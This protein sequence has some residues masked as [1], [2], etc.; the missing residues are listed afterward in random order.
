MS[1]IV[2]LVLSAV[3]TYSAYAT[4]TWFGIAGLTTSSRLRWT[5]FFV[6]AIVGGIA[7]AIV[8]WYLARR[9]PAPRS[10]DDELDLLVN[11]ANGYLASTSAT[12]GYSIGNRPVVVVVGAPG[13]AKTTTVQQSASEA[14]LLAGQVKRGGDDAPPPTPA[15]NVWYTD[16]AIVLEAGGTLLGDQERWTKLVRRIQPRR[17]FSALLKGVQPTRVALLCFSCEDL[18]GARTK[19]ELAAAVSPLHA[20][21][22]ELAASL[23]IRLPVYVL[24]TKADKVVG[25]AE[26]AAVLTREEIRSILGVTLSIDSGEAAGTY[27]ERQSQLLA[28][29]FNGLYTALALDRPRVLWREPDQ[30]QR[31]QAYEFAREFRKLSQNAVQ[32]LVDVC[33]PNPLRP[34]PV[35][36]GFYFAGVRAV[37]DQAAEDI[38]ARAG[39]L[40]A[41]AGATMMLSGPEAAAAMPRLNFSGGRVRR[42]PEW[43]FLERLLPDVIL[44]DQSA[45]G[46][47]SG[48]VR[49]ERLRRGVLALAAGV[50][51][52]LLGGAVVSFAAN[53]SLR[54]RVVAAMESVRTLGVAPGEQISVPALSHLDTLRQALDR[55]DSYEA[56]SPSLHLRWGLYSGTRLLAP[57]RRVYFDAFDRILFRQTFA[58]LGQQLAGLN[59]TAVSADLYGGE[60]S[61]LQAYLVAT[62]YPDSSSESLA[63]AFMAA[64][65][66]GRQPTDSIK[67]L[68]MAQFIHY[69][70]S[71]PRYN[72]YPS[73][74][75]DSTSVR[76]AQAFLRQ[77][78]N[79]EPVYNAMVNDANR[80]I[81][82]VIFDRDFVN[83]IVAD[84]Y[85]VPG[86]YTRDGWARMQRQFDRIANYADAA[87]WVTGDKGMSK[88]D[89]DS[90]KTRVKLLYTRDY[91]RHWKTFL[92]SARVGVGGTIPEAGPRI[93]TL[94]GANSPLL[95]LMAVASQNTNVDT[96]NIGVLFRA[97]QTVVPP[98]AP[99]GG[100]LQPSNQQ[101]VNALVA[102]GSSLTT[103]TDVKTASDA[104]N[105]VTVAARQLALTGDPSVA[106]AVRRALEAPAAAIASIQ[107]GSQQVAGDAAN[108]C[109]NFKALANRFPIGNDTP[110]VSIKEFNDV[111]RPGRQC[112]AASGKTCR[113]C[114]A[115]RAP[116]RAPDRR[117]APR[118][119]SLPEF[120]RRARSRA[121]GPIC[122][123][124]LRSDGDVHRA[125]RGSEDG[126]PDADA[127]GWAVAG[128]VE[129]RFDADG[130]VRVARQRRPPRDALVGV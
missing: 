112:S 121:G 115:T 103:G 118:F 105:N 111:F 73:L 17:A 51:L 11:A 91:V 21:L 22:S 14:V 12:H 84:A 33:R 79:G 39:A 120:P 66:G 68:A 3:V 57:A 102:L 36:R 28:D 1:R 59:S 2:K 20:A 109:D 100:L 76:T 97:A 93:Q 15:V 90:L 29:R 64:W 124:A 18:L 85:P 6:L 32:L 7:A 127:N 117:P 80:A 99:G 50:A 35:L 19:E 89:Q 96:A 13:S 119:Q 106:D 104:A 88:A 26:T 5:S 110:D 45:L 61:A 77:F 60:F 125:R 54:N 72:P 34:S 67:N 95:R 52:I 4:A 122:S 23:G 75:A 128:R 82:P 40:P 8:V 31:A 129:R 41:A 37:L 71:L 83:A 56:T 69:A 65:Q 27:V 123:R 16:R 55:L 49:V 70:G 98:N 43:L 25:F 108:F 46:L 47:A 107:K 92:A 44:S 81:K 78:K 42:K 130:D 53:R 101:Y 87:Q 94:A 86:A 58:S 38:P 74:R 30:E 62:A 10:G 9:L 63:T 114:H 126:H 113:L 48:G 24:F 116:I